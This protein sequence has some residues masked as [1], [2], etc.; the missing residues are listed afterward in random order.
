MAKKIHAIFTEKQLK[1]ALGDSFSY[2]DFD[3]DVKPYNGNTE[4]SVTGNVSNDK[5]GAPLTGDDIAAMSSPQTYSSQRLGMR[6]YAR[7]ATIKEDDKNGN[8]VDDFYDRDGMDVLTNGNKN[9]D[10]T[11]VPETVLHKME[12]LVDAMSMLSPKQKAVV[13][14]KLISSVDW[15]SLELSW[16]K[17]LAL[18]IMGTPRK[19]NQ[20]K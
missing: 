17:G 10:L 7:P 5:I 20:V 18:G 8:G 16:R 6:T 2:L 19:D 11:R 4:I 1:E 9:D 15:T 3:S 12:L 14:N 13:V